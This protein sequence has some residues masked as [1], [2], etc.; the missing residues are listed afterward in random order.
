MWHCGLFPQKSM[1][2][3]TQRFEYNFQEPQTLAPKPCGLRIPGASLQPCPSHH[4]KVPCN[5]LLKAKVRGHAEPEGFYPAA[6]S[7]VLNL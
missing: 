2:T 7:T 4:N 3:H 5:P 1:Y 6:L